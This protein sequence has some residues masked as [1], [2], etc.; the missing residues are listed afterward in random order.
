[1]QM[2][3]SNCPCDFGTYFNSYGS[4]YKLYIDCSSKNKN[5]IVEQFLKQKHE[6]KTFF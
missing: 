4:S 5:R 2:F 3:F 6:K 1:M